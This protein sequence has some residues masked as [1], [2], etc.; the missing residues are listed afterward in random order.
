MGHMAFVEAS[1]VYREE[2]LVADFLAKEASHLT[3]GKASKTTNL[4]L[5]HFVWDICPM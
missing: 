1:F 5:L 4:D 3:F 2:N